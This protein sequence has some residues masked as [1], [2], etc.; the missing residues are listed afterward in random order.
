[1][2]AEIQ[3]SNIE[4]SLAIRDCLEVV[5]LEGSQKE[6]ILSVFRQGWKFTLDLISEEVIYISIS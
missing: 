6:P 5:N 3:S 2:M 1:M 4:D